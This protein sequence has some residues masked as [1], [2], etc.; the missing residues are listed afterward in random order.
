MVCAINAEF[1]VLHDTHVENPSLSLSKTGEMCTSPEVHV[2]EYCSA[3]Q[4]GVCM[5]QANWGYLQVQ[6]S[7]RVKR[8][9]SRQRSIIHTF[10]YTCMHYQDLILPPPNHIEMKLHLALPKR[11][12]T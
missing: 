6:V 2:W 10:P 12:L 9:S 11:R 5:L 1:H 8:D 4:V 7:P 3:D